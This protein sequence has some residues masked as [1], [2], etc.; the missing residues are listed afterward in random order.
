[1][2]P[3]AHGTWFGAKSAVQCARPGCR[4]REA[5]ATGSKAGGAFEVMALRTK[6]PSARVCSTHT[7]NL[8]A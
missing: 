7:Q 8:N 2:L 6:H 3:Q 5:V 1:M 4:N